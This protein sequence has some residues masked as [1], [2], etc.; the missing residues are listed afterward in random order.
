MAKKLYYGGEVFDVADS[1][2]QSVVTTQHGRVT[3]RTK[4]G[5]VLTF[6][7]GPG[8][9]IALEESQPGTASEAP[10]APIAL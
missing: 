9:P 10:G 6:A 3:V 4:A 7:T 1:V 5:A 2:E 8:V